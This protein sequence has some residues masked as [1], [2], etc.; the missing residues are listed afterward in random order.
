MEEAE[1]AARSARAVTDALN[2][3]LR[4][5]INPQATL[6]AFVQPLGASATIRFRRLGTDLDVN[7]PEVQ[8]PLG[9]VP[10]WSSASSPYPNS[11]PPSPW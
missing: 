3:A 8:T 6:D 2:D 4:T 7:A 5:S 1:P 9:T 11:K 10:D